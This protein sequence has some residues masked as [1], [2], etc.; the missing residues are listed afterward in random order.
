MTVEIG[1]NLAG[2]ILFAWIARLLFA[3]FRRPKQ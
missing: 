2:T 1:V 3:A